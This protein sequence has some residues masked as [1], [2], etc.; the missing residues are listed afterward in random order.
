MIQVLGQLIKDV[1]DILQ[2][3][4]GQEGRQ[5]TLHVDGQDCFGDIECCVAIGNDEQHCIGQGGPH[6]PLQLS[7]QMGSAT[8]FTL[9]QYFGQVGRQCVL[10]IELHDACVGATVGR[11]VAVQH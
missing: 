7:G 5:F 2:Q 11:Y 3:N 9:Q 10:Q 4:E 1:G 8:I 6:I